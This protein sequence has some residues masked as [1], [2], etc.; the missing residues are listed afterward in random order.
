MLDNWAV[1][2]EASSITQLLAQYGWLPL[3]LKALHLLAL[4]L[5]GGSVLIA[6]LRLL[7]IGLVNHSVATLHRAARPW[8]FLGVALLLLSGI[9]LWMANAVAL[10]NEPLFQLKMIML[11]GTVL[12]AIT[13]RDV[14]VAGAIRVF[15]GPRLSVRLAGLVSLL[16]WLTVAALGRYQ[17]YTLP[18]A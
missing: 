16:L 10:T 5:V 11:V 1:A 15:R 8:F 12:Y 13:V 14:M 9:P 6:D 17:T 3:L 4:A 18:T 7:G 2:A